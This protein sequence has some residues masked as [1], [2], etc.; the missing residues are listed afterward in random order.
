MIAELKLTDLL[1]RAIVI[2]TTGMT[3]YSFAPIDDKQFKGKAKTIYDTNAKMRDNEFW[4]AHRTT[5]LT[6][7]EAGMDSLS[8]VWQ[9]Q[10]IS[11]G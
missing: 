6:K 8:S 3:N 7:S 11:N 2:R 4:A 9:A 10:S 5:Q 1:Q